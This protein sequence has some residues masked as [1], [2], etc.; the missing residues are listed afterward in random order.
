MCFIYILSRLS[1]KENSR[2]VQDASCFQNAAAQGSDSNESAFLASNASVATDATNRGFPPERRST[3]LLVGGI[4]P[5]P[6]EQ[7][8]QC[9]LRTVPAL[10]FLA[11]LRSD[12]RFL[13]FLQ[14]KD[15]LDIGLVDK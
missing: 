1:L 3:V 6:L 15:V 4:A 10:F 2:N 9:W 13:L 14:A 12:F 11:L 8:L 5:K 7:H